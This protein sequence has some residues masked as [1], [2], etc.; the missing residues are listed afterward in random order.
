MDNGNVVPVYSVVAHEQPPGETHL[1]GVFGV[2]K[3]CRRGLHVQ[4]LVI[5][6]QHAVQGWALVDRFLKIRGGDP[7]RLTRMLHK[8]LE[9]SGS[10]T[11][12]DWHAD[13]TLSSDQSHLDVAAVNNSDNG[14]IAGLGEVNMSDRLVGLDQNP[15]EV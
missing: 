7:Q 9:R 12:H 14:R 15:L 5:A 10:D 11:E 8:V 4:S 6:Q 2:G 3:S 13:Q 1:Q